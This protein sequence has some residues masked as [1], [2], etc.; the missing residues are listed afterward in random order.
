MLMEIFSLTVQGV[1]DAK[2]GF[3]G[4]KLFKRDEPIFRCVDDSNQDFKGVGGIIF[5]IVEPEE[6][7]NKI[8]R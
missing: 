1:R 3:K 8:L 6:F 2:K 4:L 7:P 5:S